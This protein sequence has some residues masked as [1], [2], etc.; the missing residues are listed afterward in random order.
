LEQRE[1][2]DKVLARVAWILAPMNQFGKSPGRRLEGFP[3]SS[4]SSP[5]DS[6]KCI[7][8]K[9][10]HPILPYFWTQELQPVKSLKIAGPRAADFPGTI[11]SFYFPEVF[12][13]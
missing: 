10:W 6:F 1:I 7:P 8:P 3:S 9:K 4:G 5:E 11:R 12:Y 13:G 2:Y